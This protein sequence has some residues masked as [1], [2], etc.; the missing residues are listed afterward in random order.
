MLGNSCG[1]YGDMYLQIQN[2]TYGQC[3]WNITCLSTTLQFH[4]HDFSV[5]QLVHATPTT[6]SPL[7]QES[8]PCFLAH[9]IA[10]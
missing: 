4:W 5:D 7:F 9:P 8:L 1:D 6:D 3:V 10:A 2:L